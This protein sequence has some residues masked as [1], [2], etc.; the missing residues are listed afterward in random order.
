M[1]W[2]SY[3]ELWP[4]NIVEE[5]CSSICLE[6]LRKSAITVTTPLGFIEEESRVQLLHSF[7]LMSQSVSQSFILALIYGSFRQL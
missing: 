6:G 1:E 7:T 5:S 4:E 2:K 3:Y